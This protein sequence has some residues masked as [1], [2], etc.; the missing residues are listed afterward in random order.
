MNEAFR[1]QPTF[2]PLQL[3]RGVLSVL[4][5][6]VE[7]NPGTKQQNL[8]QAQASFDECLR[9]TNGRNMM[10]LLGK[11]RVLFARRKY[12]E[13]HKTYQQV[14]IRAPDLIEP[15]PRIGLGCCLWQLSYLG[16][17]GDNAHLKEHAQLAWQRA[18][19]LNPGSKVATQLLGLFYLWKSSRLSTDDPEFAKLYKKAILEH[20]QKVFKSDNN[21]P[22]ANATFGS[23]FFSQGTS[24]AMEK[25]ERTARKAIDLTDSNA[26]AS[27]GWYLLARKEHQ[28]GDTVKALEYYQRADAARGGTEQDSANRNQGYLPARFGIAQIRMLQGDHKGAERALDRIDPNT[29]RSKQYNLETPALL[30]L[31]SAEEIFNPPPPPIDAAE[32]L[33]YEERQRAAAKRALE[34][35]SAAQRI[36]Q[37]SNRPLKLDVSVLLNLARLSESYSLDERGLLL[38]NGNA[39]KALECLLQVQEFE[40]NEYSDDDRPE[41]P[42]ELAMWRDALSEQLSPQ[43]LNNIGCF[44]YRTERFGEAQDMFQKASKACTKLEGEAGADADALLTTIMFNLGRSLEALRNFEQAKEVYESV[45]QR[46]ADYFDARIRLAFITLVLNPG[47]E[48]KSKNLKVL[49]DENSSH[50]EVRALWGWYL[51]KTKRRNPR[52]NEDTE[53]RHFKRSLQ[54]YKQPHDQ[55]SL[56]AMGNIVL[57]HAREDLRQENQKQQRKE[58]YERAM[59]FFQKALQY[60]PSNAYAAQGLAIWMIE[61]QRKL[62]EAMQLLLQVKDSLT[63]DHS[64][65][66]NLAHLYC[67]L[68]Q[69]SRAIENYE[70]ALHKKAYENA[71]LYA[72]SQSKMDIGILGCLSRAWL[73]KGKQDRDLN[74][75]QK[76][77]EQSRLALDHSPEQPVPIHLKFNIAFV[78]TNLAQMIRAIPERGRTLDDV[79]Q[80]ADDVEEAITIL[81]DMRGTSSLPAPFDK[82]YIEQLANMAKNTLRRQME[83]EVQKQRDYEEKNADRLLRAREAREAELQ[84]QEE[85][86]QEREA[87]E[88]ETRRRIA[89]ER[90][91]MQDVDRQ[92]A[93]EREEEE[94]RQREAEE[95]EYDSEGNLVEKKGK[96]KKGA[97]RKK[98]TEDFIN[99]DEDV[100]GVNGDGTHADGSEATPAASADERPRKK[101]KR[102]LEMR[103]SQK[104]SKYKSADTIDSDEDLP[105]E[106]A[107][108]ADDADAAPEK[109]DTE[110]NELFDDGEDGDVNMSDGAAEASNL[111]RKAKKV[112]DDEDDEEDDLPAPLE[113]PGPTGGVVDAGNEDDEGE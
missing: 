1:I 24:Q 48:N 26:I 97:K 92:I 20:T 59:L 79:T 25:V 73:Y 68:Q 32:E 104:T 60:D 67:E 31:L 64:V 41:D 66:L 33:A 78:E 113:L 2:P 96:K 47:E 10:A 58:E 85:E 16:E 22:L 87:Q 39:A 101:K 103:S 100:D 19:E 4:R 98:K 94:K 106:D 5:A 44:H 91:K 12:E 38:T 74:A 112:I 29:T 11:A 82:S 81:E 63:K 65:F 108:D 14:L 111:A 80:A 37:R 50:M 53:Q 55:Y 36:W 18:L 3:A 76:A 43:L 90:K 83:R 109:M 77:L 23:Y 107:G 28:S 105:A 69:Y 56:T 49:H 62:S 21:F 51:H 84:R 72:R 88:A 46:H 9:S 110:G 15:D 70:L 30:G 52:L 42:E 61:D 35:L 57:V 27:D 75:M 40:M 102:R 45:L 71:G 86:R 99:D 34:Y 17:G 93:A 54:N 8:D 7:V 6:G 13:A 95:P 89:E